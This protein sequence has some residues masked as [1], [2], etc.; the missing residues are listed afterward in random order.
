MASYS[1]N[2]SFWNG[3]SMSSRVFVKVHCFYTYQRFSASRY[4][5]GKTFASIC[6]CGDVGAD[7]ENFI[8]FVFYWKRSSH[9]YRLAFPKPSK[10]RTP[11]QFPISFLE[12]HFFP[13]PI[14][15]FPVQP[16]PTSAPNATVGGTHQYLLKVAGLKTTC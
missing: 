2:T 14:S 11:N 15:S 8:T 1:P 12:G 16:Q 6:C 13:P 7:L 4:T 5:T 10:R 3:R 9:E